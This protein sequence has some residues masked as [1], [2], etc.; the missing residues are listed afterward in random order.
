MITSQHLVQVVSDEET[1]LLWRRRGGIEN[2]LFE[3]R[4][5]GAWQVESIKAVRNLAGVSLAE[6]KEIV[7]FSKTWADTREAS[8]DLHESAY[9]SLGE[10]QRNDPVEAERLVAQIQSR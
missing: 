2:F 3:L 1:R 8:E 5:H 10:I 6:A 4:S 9:E 7:H